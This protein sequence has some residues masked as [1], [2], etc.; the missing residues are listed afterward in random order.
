MGRKADFKLTFGMKKWR[1]ISDI[2]EDGDCVKKNV[3]R[4]LWRKEYM[5]QHDEQNENMKI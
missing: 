2:T 3:T 5:D 4:K 1:V